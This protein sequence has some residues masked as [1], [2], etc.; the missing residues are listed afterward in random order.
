LTNNL[1][2]YVTPMLGREREAAEIARAVEQAQLVTI[3]GAGGIGKTR[4]AVSVA[5][6]HRADVSDG[7]WFVDLAPL[8]DP[9]LIPATV[10]NAMGLDL[11][12]SADPTAALANELSRRRHRTCVCLQRVS[13]RSAS[14]ERPY[15]GSMHSMKSQ[16]SPSSKNERGAS[17]PILNLR[18]RMKS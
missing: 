17:F 4:V 7:T 3:V 10:A 18:K 6:A 11:G 8:S 16:V 5:G 14:S 9:S 13:N 12:E 2:R 15:T 1:P